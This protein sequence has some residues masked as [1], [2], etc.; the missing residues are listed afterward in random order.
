MKTLKFILLFVLFFTLGPNELFAQE[1][2]ISAGGEATGNGG[3]VSF[4][5]GQFAYQ[6]INGTVGSLAEGLQQPYEISMVTGMREND[7]QLKITAYPNPTSDYLILK[8]PGELAKDHKYILIDISGKTL[9]Q[10]KIIAN[11]TEIEMGAL[12]AG[13]YFITVLAGEQKVQTFKI[14]KNQDR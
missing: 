9:D 6:T 13:S 11:E 1:A 7:I 4:T 12:D 5:V 10:Q 2:N 8:I 3:A 14:I